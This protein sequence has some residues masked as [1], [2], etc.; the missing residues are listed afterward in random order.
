MARKIDKRLSGTGFLGEPLQQTK[1]TILEQRFGVP[2]FSVLNTNMD[3][4]QKRRSAWLRLGLKGEEGRYTSTE[5]REKYGNKGQGASYADS[6]TGHGMDLRMRYEVQNIA[7][8]MGVDPSEVDTSHLKSKGKKE[9]LTSVFDPVLAELMYRWFTIPGGRILDPFAGEATK[10]IVATM[11]GYDYTG[12][13]LRDVQVEAN[14]KQA[15]ALGL[16]PNWICGDSSEI[17][18]YTVNH[19]PY[20]LVFT[21]PPYFSLEIYSQS[22]K[23]GSSMASYEKFMEWYEDIFA[24][25]VA[26]LK[27]NRFLVVKVSE[28]RDPKTGFYVN[29]VP[30]NV[31][32]FERLGLRFYDE[33]I[34]VNRGGSLPLRAGK[35]FDAYRKIGRQHQN[36]LVFWNGDNCRDIHEEI[37]EPSNKAV[38]EE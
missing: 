24:K 28:V 5:E 25:T 10:G 21:S 3:Y 22:E 2:P 33:L 31:Y 32:M 13:E 4:W 6:L 35:H 15:A 9:D 1:R 11:L 37:V 17:D 23:D 18:Q 14:R 36:I 12:I 26:K 7:A 8:R 20:D 30:D 27:K 29:F 16:E 19:E 34:L 38:R